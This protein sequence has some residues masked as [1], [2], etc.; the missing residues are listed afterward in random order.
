MWVGEGI[1][2][3]EPLHNLHM[4]WLPK[5]GCSPQRT[6]RIH[7]TL[8]LLTIVLHSKGEKGQAHMFARRVWRVLVAHS[9]TADMEIRLQKVSTAMSSTFFWLAS[10]KNLVLY[11]PR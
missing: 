6:E 1:V 10:I 9:L 11:W 2:Q 7:H 4:K 8:R 3:R 5:T